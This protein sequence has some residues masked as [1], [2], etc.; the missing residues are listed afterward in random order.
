MIGDRRIKNS[1]F[2]PAWDKFKRGREEH[3]IKNSSMDGTRDDERINVAG[4]GS[5]E[6]EE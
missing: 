6:V 2:R 4:R 1:I 5:R 3:L